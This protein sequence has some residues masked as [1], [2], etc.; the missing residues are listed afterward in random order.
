MNT[1]R[2]AGWPPATEQSDEPRVSLGSLVRRWLATTADIET[3]RRENGEEPAAAWAL[4][5]LTGAVP[6]VRRPADDRADDRGDDLEDRSVSTEDDR[7]EVPDPDVERPPLPHRRR[8][9]TPPRPARRLAVLIDARTVPPGSSDGLFEVLGDHGTV[10][11]SRAYGDWTSYTADEWMPRLRHHGIQPC[12]QFGDP[13]TTHLDQ[14][15]LVAMTI[16]AVDLACQGAVD[17]VALVGDLASAY[18]LVQRLNASGIAVLA[19]G[20]AETPGDVRGLCEEFT[21]LQLLV[22]GGT[23]AS[24][25]HRA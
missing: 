18:P 17:A 23:P 21:D 9:L 14:R 7:A 5:D 25:R 3:R 20:P 16:D 2:T 15:S 19:F 11:V 4:P 1:T 6:A 24:G 22:N 8:G 12:H 13:L 10:N